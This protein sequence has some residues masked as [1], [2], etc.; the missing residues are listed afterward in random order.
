MVLRSLVC[1]VWSIDGVCIV[2]HTQ[3]EALKLRH[4]YRHADATLCRILAAGR[5]STTL[6]GP[7]RSALLLMTT[8][9]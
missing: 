4:Q 2:F 6:I 5:S 1:I 9:A 7:W 3:L 8:S